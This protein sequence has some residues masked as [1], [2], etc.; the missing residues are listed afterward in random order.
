MEIGITVLGGFGGG[1]GGNNAGG[2]DRYDDT[3]IK[4]QLARLE[5][6]VAHI[7][8]NEI[9]MNLLFSGMAGNSERGI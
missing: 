4:K 9:V 2:S 8:A 3:A 1:N 5:E 7:E 6:R